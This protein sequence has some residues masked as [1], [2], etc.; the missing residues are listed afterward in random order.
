MVNNHLNLNDL[1]IFALVVKNK[2]FTKAAQ[3]SGLSK[4][5][6]SLKISHLEDI[7][8][9]Q[10]LKRT[11]R[12]LGLTQG[13]EILF[14]HCQKMLKEVSNAENYL[15]QYTKAPSGK[16]VITCPGITGQKLMPV[17]LDQFRAKYP[18]IHTRL[19][20]TDELLDLTQQGIDFAFRTGKL[21]DSTLISRFIGKVPRCLVASLSYLANYPIPKHP[22]ELKQHHL[23][24][25][26]LLNNWPLKN[27]KHVYKFYVRNAVS[28]SNSL[29]YL[30]AMSCAGNGIAFLPYY[31][32]AESIKHKKLVKVLPKW[33][34][35][36]NEYYLIYHKEKSARYINQ[37]FKDFILQSN[38]AAMIAGEVIV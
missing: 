30:L 15:Q 16:L 29:F 14:E 2:S 11:T 1:A 12:S 23:L 37:L 38:L 27:G 8:G 9:L 31:L 3:E 19:I 34:N 28:E 22:D 25:H 6:V 10:L 17:L 18:G 32:C 7:L 36:D 13:G 35:L 20:I 24:K 26:T 33:F 21:A 4:A 5:W